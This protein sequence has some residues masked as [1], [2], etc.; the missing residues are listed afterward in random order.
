M[1]S[2]A[3]GGLRHE[4]QPSPDSNTCRSHHLHYV[5]RRPQSGPFRKTGIAR[6]ILRGARKSLRKACRKP[7]SLFCRGGP[8]TNSGESWSDSVNREHLV[9]IAIYDA[10]GKALAMS[11][12]LDSYV[13]TPPAYLP[14]SEE[15]NRGVGEYEPIGKLT[16]YVYAVPLHR[17][18]RGCRRSGPI[19]RCFLHRG[20]KQHDLARRALARRRSSSTDH[21]DYFLC[22]SVDD[23]RADHK[24][25][26]MDE[27][28]AER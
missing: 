17:G 21:I 20:P 11:P 19:S 22:D 12:K 2:L 28:S 27:G 16:M 23:R 13:E 15:K 5:C 7:W 9:G 6:Q 24:S 4:T 3:N 8:R 10:D 25:C 14:K 1:Q 18:Y 26:A